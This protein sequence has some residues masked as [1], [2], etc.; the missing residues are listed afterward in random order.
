MTCQPCTTTSPSSAKAA[1][2]MV[3]PARR[4]QVRC[5]RDEETGMAV[6]DME[7]SGKF[8]DATVQ[9]VDRR[10][11]AVLRQQ[12]LCGGAERGDVGVVELHA[13]LD[14]RAPRDLFLLRP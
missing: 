2:A 3:Q 12:R 8:A 6:A 1:T 9:R 10:I 7:S 11:A 5:R 4:S 13:G 14:H